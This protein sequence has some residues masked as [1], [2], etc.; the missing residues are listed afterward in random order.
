MLSLVRINRA[1]K[2]NQYLGWVVCELG[3]VVIRYPELRSDQPALYCSNGVHLSLTFPGGP[4]VGLLG[5][6]LFLVGRRGPSARLTQTHT[7]VKGSM[8]GIGRDVLGVL[9]KVAR[10]E[11]WLVQII[12][13]WTEVAK[14][15]LWLC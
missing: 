11:I 2:L 1:R 6:L 4:A 10:L 13:C 12:R 15:D 3:G 14:A 7:P 8:L 5:T 9:P